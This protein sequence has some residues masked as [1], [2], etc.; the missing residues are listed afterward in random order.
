[1]ER[2]SPA[3]HLPPRAARRRRSRRRGITL[4][5]ISVALAL[6]AVICALAVQRVRQ[7]L[8]LA[9]STEAVQMV[10]AIGRA[11]S[12]NYAVKNYTTATAKAPGQTTTPAFDIGLCRDSVAVP[13]N[14]AAVE[15][16]KKYQP[17][18]TPG[19]DYQSGSATAGWKCIGFQNDQPQHY[20]YRYKVGGSPVALTRPLNYPAGVTAS[21]QW[22]AYARGDVDGD[23]KYSW[24]ILSGYALG[25]EVTIASGLAI[26]DQ[27]E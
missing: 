9:R 12:T 4:V 10:G 8:A 16:R 13:A 2:R 23:G 27:E 7:H 14:L 5:E 21:R 20:Q 3:L 24:F 22:T 17:R 26:Q 6:V 19:S 18:N 15:K 11:I 25:Q 1:M